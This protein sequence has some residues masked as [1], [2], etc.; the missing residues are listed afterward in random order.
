MQSL[1]RRDGASTE[2]LNLRLGCELDPHFG[3]RGW[4]RVSSAP[5]GWPFDLALHR[6][7]S[8][9]HSFDQIALGQN[10]LDQNALDQNKLKRFAVGSRQ[11]AVQ[12]EWRCLD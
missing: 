5:D 7:A 12:S 8:T 2:R 3:C 11:R 6:L 1:N 10:A 4:R 9:P